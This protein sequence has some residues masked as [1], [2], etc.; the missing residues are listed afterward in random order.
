MHI[1]KIQP[2]IR[3]MYKTEVQKVYRI[4][5]SHPGNIRARTPT[6]SSYPT[7]SASWPLH[8]LGRL[9][10]SSKARHGSEERSGGK[11]PSGSACD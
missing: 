7:A 4:I 3:G 2:V 8:S 5:H 10:V 11:I 1:A 9:S 6:T